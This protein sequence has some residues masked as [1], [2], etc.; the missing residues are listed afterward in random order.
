MAKKPSSGEKAPTSPWLKGVANVKGIVP[1][2]RRLSPTS[3]R[4]PTRW[5]ASGVTGVRP[6]GKQKVGENPGV[7]WADK[8]A[9]ER[10]KAVKSTERKLEQAKTGK[11]KPGPRGAEVEEALF[12]PLR[13]MAG[14]V[15]DAFADAADPDDL[16]AFLDRVSEFLGQ[17][18]P[19]PEVSEHF[20]QL[21]IQ[22]HAPY[23]IVVAFTV[24]NGLVGKS[25]PLRRRYSLALERGA[26]T[27]YNLAMRMNGQVKAPRGLVPETVDAL[28][29][30]LPPIA[31]Q[32]PFAYATDA[33]LRMFDLLRD[34][35]D[36][37]LDRSLIEVSRELR[38]RFIER[39]SFGDQPLARMFP[40]EEPE[41]AP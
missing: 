34:G 7:A 30:D 17:N 2:G 6:P 19:N 24:L 35:T 37:E 14:F 9:K 13:P 15:P 40:W 4:R 33:F 26:K 5:S 1:P 3:E 25:T 21:I 39:R 27:F 38:R 29:Y 11:K 22:S 31:F 12:D 32:I 16:K 28:F 20:G 23:E 8:E 41:W 18:R 36:L 10:A